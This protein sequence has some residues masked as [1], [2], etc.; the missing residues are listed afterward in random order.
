MALSRSA[1]ALALA[2]ATVLST[3]TACGV[4]EVGLRLS[5][6]S[7]PLFSRPDETTGSST[8]PG[9]AGWST[10]E[11]HA[12][13][14][15]N[16]SGFRDREHTLEKPPDVFRIAVL[17]DSYTEA[18]QVQLDAT[19]PA[20]LERELGACAARGS[21]RAEVLSFGGS[22][23]G[24]AQE[25]LVLRRHVW[26]F[27]PDL[28]VLAFYTANDVRNNSRALEPDRVRPFFVRDGSGAL[29]ADMSFRDTPD[30]R[31]ALRLAPW[32]ARVSD[33]SRVFQLVHR[34]RIR[35]KAGAIARAKET[36]RRIGGGAY[37][38]PA[39]HDWRAAWDVTEA[40]LLEMSRE[41]GQ[42]GARFLLVTLGSPEQVN[43][44]PRVSEQVARDFGVP[45]L[46]YPDTR[47]S[48]LA[49]RNG[50]DA[51]A[52][53]PLMVQASRQTGVS[54]HG[55]PNIAPNT[56]HWN[57]KGHAFAGR[58]IAAHLCAQWAR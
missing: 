19:F 51:L 39:G 23:Y 27:A 14:E 29:R 46:T 20:V 10:E 16:S 7:F 30:F 26:R 33:H 15:I 49:A 57:E 11:G 54:F 52:L 18:M 28:V 58:A 53:A 8:R 17:G 38:P 12:Y 48:A 4:A 35:L 56:G 50:I 34:T 32:W 24:T 21:R 3:L 37:A 5:G 36:N 47:L 43:P 31:R 45:D 6:F 25:L 41:V 42:H 2:S 40:L 55:F 22:S 9:V 13:V 1:K 44:D